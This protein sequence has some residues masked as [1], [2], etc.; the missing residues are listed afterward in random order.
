MIYIIIGFI[1][2]YIAWQIKMPDGVI[3]AHAILIS[4][5]SIMDKLWD[6]KIRL[7]EIENAIKR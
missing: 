3:I 1:D 2:V 5:W 6:I 4:A 7:T